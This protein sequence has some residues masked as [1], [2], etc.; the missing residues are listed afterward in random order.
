MSDMGSGW[1]GDEGE[2]FAVEPTDRPNQR[3]CMGCK[4]WIDS[5]AGECYL[6]GADAP[7][8]NVALKNAIQSERLNANIYA[9]GN[10]A[11]QEK[12]VSAS[13]PQN[14]KGAGP[15]RLYNI[16]GAKDLASHYKSELQNSGFGE[17]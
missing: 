10:R 9:T 1:G 14:P 17:K 8:T 11:L 12:R 7:R 15:T 6:C 13:I 2:E 16:A 3:L 4:E 5:R